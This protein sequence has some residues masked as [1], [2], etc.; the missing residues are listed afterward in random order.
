MCKNQSFFKI[1]AKER[2]ESQ[3]TRRD[4]K[5][6]LMPN[7]SVREISNGNIHIELFC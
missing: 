2:K 7:D 5:H 3:N 4:W 6:L 1:S